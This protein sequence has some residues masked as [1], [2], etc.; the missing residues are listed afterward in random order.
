MNTNQNNLPNEWFTIKGTY[1]YG[2]FNNEE[3]IH[4]LQENLIFEYDLV[5]NP[6][7][8]HWTRIAELEDFKPEAIVQTGKSAEEL[9]A[10]FYRRKHRRVKCD[11]EVLIHDGD[12][13]W[14]AHTLDISP[15]GAG[16]TMSTSGLNL[17]AEIHIHFKIGSDVPPFNAVC[18][19]VNLHQKEHTESFRYGLKFISLD[20]KIFK[21]LE[22]ESKS[23]EA[24]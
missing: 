8:S 16:L 21:L 4:M 9:K 11:G 22:K 23:K 5:W 20:K 6:K 15:S 1:K 14:K 18:R 24:A 7:L 12:K 10:S 17:G 3:V 2:P 19:V 13:V